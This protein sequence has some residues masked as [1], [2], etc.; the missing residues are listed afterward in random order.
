MQL[1]LSN[2][3]RLIGYLAV[4]SITKPGFA[5]YKPNNFKKFYQDPN[6]VYDAMLAKQPVFF[7]PTMASWIVSKYDDVQN[8]LRDPRLSCDFNQWRFAAPSTDNSDWDKVT[9]GLLFTLDKANHGRIRRLTT[10]AFGPKTLDKIQ[11]ATDKIVSDCFDNLTLKPGQELDFAEQVAAYIPK[12][13]IAELVGVKPEDQQRFEGFTGCVMTLFDPAQTP[14]LSQADSGIAMMQAYIAQR[15]IEPGD[16]F[17]SLL[18]SHVEDGDRISEWEAIALIASLIAAGPDT[19][20]DDLNFGLYNLLLQ[21]TTL[22]QLIKDPSL[23][24]KVI[25]ESTRW[26]HFGYSAP[27]RFALED[28]EI[29]GHKIKRGEMIR[30]IIPAA[31]RDPDVFPEPD[32]YDLERENNNKVMRFGSGPHY[33]VGSAIAQTIAKTTL[34]EFLKRYPNVAFSQ[35]KPVYEKHLTS[36][37]MSQFIVKV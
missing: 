29:G 1:P 11:A 12:R 26:N 9:G 19:S 37:R 34:L 5:A 14:D 13:V 36:R 35:H 17:L 23:I 18:I 8:S 10:P 2:L 15:K 32:K 4:N 24:D 33:C 3:I 22:S 6:P 28:V 25:T 20:R 21:P 7:A 30:L 31:H 16:D 27:I